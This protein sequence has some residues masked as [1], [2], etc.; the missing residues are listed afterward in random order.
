MTNV[1]KVIK[2]DEAKQEINAA[3][4]KLIDEAQPKQTL[5][6]IYDKR[7][8]YESTK[9]Q[10]LN[11]LSDLESDNPAWREKEWRHLGCLYNEVYLDEDEVAFVG[12]REGFEFNAK[13]IALMFKAGAQ[14]ITIDF[15]NYWKTI[16]NLNDGEIIKNTYV[17]CDGVYYFY[18]KPSF[19]RDKDIKAGRAVQITKMNEELILHKLG[20]MKKR[21][22]TDI[23]NNCDED[24]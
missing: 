20:E 14:V 7:N 13:S 3:Q 10:L 9:S 24:Y 2:P 8:A 22:D 21:A 19:I 17:Y 11:Q 18:D 12:M 6:A 5:R 4:K 23:H 15:E 16:Y 1:A